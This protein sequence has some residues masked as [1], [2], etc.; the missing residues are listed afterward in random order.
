[1]SHQAL[2]IRIGWSAKSAAH[3][4]EDLF[5]IVYFNATPTIGWSQISGDYFIGK[6]LIYGFH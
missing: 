3:Y 6:L 1:M 4:F 2:R 5:K